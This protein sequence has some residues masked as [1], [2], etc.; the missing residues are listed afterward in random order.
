MD[1]F[2][3]VMKQVREIREGRAKGAI[4]EQKRPEPPLAISEYA[5]KAAAKADFEAKFGAWFDGRGKL[6][7]RQLL[8]YSEAEEFISVANAEQ[9]RWDAIRIHFQTTEG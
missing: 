6:F 5:N 7:E 2:D 8:S 1:I 4:A 3:A 9:A